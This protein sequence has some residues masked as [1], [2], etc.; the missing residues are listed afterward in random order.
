MMKHDSR[1]LQISRR[2]FRHDPHLM[3]RHRAMRFVFDSGNLAAIFA[4]SHQL[5][6]NRR[7]RPRRDRFRPSGKSSGASVSETSQTE[8]AMRYWNRIESGF[9]PIPGET[10][11]IPK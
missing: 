5:P 2:A 8:I 4:R 3:F 9:T 10:K 6:K 11:E 7:S 1:Q